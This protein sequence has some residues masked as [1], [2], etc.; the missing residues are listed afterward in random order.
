MDALTKLSRA[1]YQVL[2]SFALSERLRLET[3]RAA[4]ERWADLH[5]ELETRLVIARELAEERRHVRVVPM[6]W[7]RRRRITH[8]RARRVVLALATRLTDVAAWIEEAIEEAEE[9][10]RR[11]LLELAAARETLEELKKFRM[12]RGSSPPDM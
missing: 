3:Y 10:A 11:Y 7:R 2:F 4:L 8:A 12:A 6:P 5:V 1:Q 9:S